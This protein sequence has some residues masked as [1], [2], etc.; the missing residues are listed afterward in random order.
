M[1]NYLR[2]GPGA[3]DYVKYHLTV[4]SRSNGALSHSQHS[5]NSLS[6]IFAASVPI[7]TSILTYLAPASRQ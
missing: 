5:A 1:S 6:I 3:L 4:R 2:V 7:P